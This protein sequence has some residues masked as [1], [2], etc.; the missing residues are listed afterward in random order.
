MQPEADW[1]LFIGDESYLIS[2]DGYLMPV[3]KGQKP[4]DL[5]YFGQAQK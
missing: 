1:H 3:K 5:R 4:P 2:E